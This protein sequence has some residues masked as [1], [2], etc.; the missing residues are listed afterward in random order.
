M[1]EKALELNKNPVSDQEL[2]NEGESYF[3]LNMHQYAIYSFERSIEL[4]PNNSQSVRYRGMCYEKLEKFKDIINSFK[5]PNSDD[6]DEC[7]MQKKLNSLEK[8]NYLF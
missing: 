7:P 5:N 2:C 1:F 3:G 6:N 4:N 8:G